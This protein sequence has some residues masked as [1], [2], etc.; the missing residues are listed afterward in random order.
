MGV[1]H[2]DFA[3]A[4]GPFCEEDAFA[5][6]FATEECS[7]AFLNIIQIVIMDVAN[8]DGVGSLVT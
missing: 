3:E 7:Q 5:K 6:G 2:Q 1:K 4:L 8:G